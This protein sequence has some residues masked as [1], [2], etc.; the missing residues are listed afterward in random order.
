MYCTIVIMNISS[1]DIYTR[2]CTNL[3]YVVCWTFVQY[4][5]Y[6]Y[7]TLLC[8]VPQSQE[9]MVTIIHLIY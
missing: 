9:R 1:K 7:V 2:I 8:V 3:T 4:N 5:N 6:T